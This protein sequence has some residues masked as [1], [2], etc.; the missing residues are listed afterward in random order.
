MRSLSRDDAQKLVDTISPRE[1]RA[2]HALMCGTGIEIGA[3]LTLRR[4]DIDVEAGTI[5]AHGT[6]RAHRDRVV[7]VTEPWCWQIVLEWLEARRALPDAPVFQISYWAATDA[8][9]RALKALKWTNYRSHDWRHTYA[10]QA[11]RDGEVPQVVAHQLGHKT[12]AMVY[13]VYG[14]YAPTASDY[15]S[16]LT[17]G[18]TVAPKDDVSAPKNRV[19]I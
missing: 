2:V 12:P 18:L 15:C 13:A 17:V 6:K 19:A 11:L 10:V 1:A 7:R 3:A 8:L 16:R 9:E 5:H 14:R 4:R